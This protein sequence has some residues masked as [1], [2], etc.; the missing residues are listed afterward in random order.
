MPEYGAVKGWNNRIRIGVSSALNESIWKAGRDPLLNSFSVETGVDIEKISVIGSRQPVSIVEGVTEVS[1]SIERNLYSKNATY[2]EF[3]YVNDT[4]HYDLLKATGLGGEAGLECKILWN[5]LSNDP[6]DGYK[7]VITNVKFHDYRIAHAARDVVVE[8]VDY[9]ASRL[10]IIKPGKQ[11]V[12]I[13]GTN[14]TLTNYQ[15]KIILNSSNFDFEHSV[16]DSSEIYFTDKNGSAISHWIE[17]WSDNRAVIWCKVPVI[18]ANTSTHIWMLYGYTAEH[19]MSDGDSTFEFFD[20]TFYSFC[21]PLKNA[22]SYQNIPTYDGSGQCTHPDVVY[23][24]SGW[25]GYKYWM[26]MTPYPNGSDYYENPSIVVSN[27]GA[28]WEVPPGLTN[29]IDPTPPEGHNCDPDMIYNDDTDELWLYYVEKVNETSYLKRRTSSDG[30]HWNEEEEVLSGKITSPAIVKVGSF[31]HM[32]YVE[33]N[34]YS[35]STTVKYRVSEDGLDWSSPQNVNISQPDYIVWHLDVIHIP[36]KN[37]Y[38]MLFPGFPSGSNCANTVLFYAKST[39]KM[40]WV[41]YNR[42]ALN[43]GSGWDGDQI[44]RSTFLYDSSS[45]LLKVWY[46]ARGGTSWHIGYTQRNYNDFL[47][48]LKAIDKW[49]GDLAF[50]YVDDGILIYNGNGAWH[51]SFSKDS[52]SPPMAWR[53]KAY[54]T[55]WNADTG[56]RREAD[57][58]GRSVFEA[59]NF[60]SFDDDGN[61]EKTENV[62]EYNTWYILD[63]LQLSGTKIEAIV[64]GETKAIHTTRV[65]T[66]P[67]NVAVASLDDDIKL[68]WVLVRKYNDPEPIVII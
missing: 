5:P 21:Q 49:K 6:D 43:K 67:V 10:Q 60:F 57:S 1:G 11:M 68:D 48:Y 52:Y 16:S 31:Y 45:N 42:I 34:C 62:Y 66:I 39:D 29:P 41:T 17:S 12:T 7:R 25:H 40:N 19:P 30:V 54:F 46:S 13:L 36:S 65:G 47:T 24:P 37:E 27:D 58:N 32:W 20:D 26:A 50:G 9:D 2:N 4:T 59:K 33:G 56:F 22:N 51:K 35:T 23:F 44:Y 14:T 55:D 64:D 38:W 15:V 53:A 28:S 3:I 63:I 61:Y 8:S 18:P